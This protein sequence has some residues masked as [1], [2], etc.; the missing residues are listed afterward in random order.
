MSPIDVL[1]LRD[2]INMLRVDRYVDALR[3]R[4][5][6][7]TVR[8]ADTPAEKQ[9]LA[10]R[11]RVIS[12]VTI[13]P[14]LIRE[15]EELALFAGVAAGYDHLPLDVFAEEGVA[16]TNGSGIHAPNIAEQVLGYILDHVRNFRTGRRQQR[17]NVWQHYRAG[18]LKGSTVMIVG[19]GSIGQA[20][21]QRVSAFEVDTVGVRYS[22]EKGGPT[23][24]VIGFSTDEFSREL[25]GTDYLIVA[26]PLSETT[27]GLIDE[28]VLQR[29]PNHAYLVNIARGE[30]V[31]TDALV[32]AI[33]RNWIGGAALDVTDPEPLPSDHQLWNF[34]NVTITPHMAGHSPSI[35]GRLADLVAENVRLLDTD[36]PETTFQNEIQT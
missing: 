22:P 32:D 6:E 16:V 9:R 21:A 5:P 7:D 36:G 13:D 17:R 19:L 34:E 12:S 4:L 30:I 18:E 23:D 25:V 10:S 27:R 29:L 15:A 33:Q 8:V 31:D 14:S 3:E 1:V 35:Y 2:E 26:S 20:I 24:S 28:G 11:A